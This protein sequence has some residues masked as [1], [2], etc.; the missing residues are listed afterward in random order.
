[1]T[2]VPATSPDCRMASS[3][4]SGRNHEVA[5][6]VRRERIIAGR[7]QVSGETGV[8]DQPVP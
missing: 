8:I 3:P 1:M 5:A 4:A 2:I 6:I 7:R